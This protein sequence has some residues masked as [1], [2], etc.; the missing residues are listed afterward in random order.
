[1]RIRSSII[2]QRL[3]RQLGIQI[4]T[5]FITAHGRKKCGCSP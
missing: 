5:I 2:V 4:A 3:F 1:V